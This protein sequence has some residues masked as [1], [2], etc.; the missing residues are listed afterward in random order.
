MVLDAIADPTVAAAW[1]LPS[2]LEGQNVSGLA[3]HLAR[4]GVWVVADYLDAGTPPGPVDFDSA[5][6]YFARFVSDASP[7]DARAIRDRGAAVAAVG[8]DELLFTLAERLNALGPRLASLESDHLIAVAGGKV[9]RLE[10]YLTTRIVEQTVHL[11]DLAR[12]LDRDP[13]PL[14]AN[15]AALT[16]A[17]G[18]EIARRRSGATAVI[19]TLYRHG[20]AGSTL[21]VL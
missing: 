16:I 17:V 15:S 5:G 9:M 12:S 6:E 13:W 1:D 2:V 21:P 20:L 10:D 11:D 8:R 19:R 18:V 7:D 3:G 4:G 14:P